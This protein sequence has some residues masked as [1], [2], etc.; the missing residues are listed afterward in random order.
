MRHI[1]L[2][3]VSLIIITL[4]IT[5]SCVCTACAKSRSEFEKTAVIVVGE[6]T[7]RY[8]SGIAI[9]IPGKKTRDVLT[10]CSN[11]LNRNGTVPKTA[12]VIF[13]AAA[14]KSMT[15]QVVDYNTE[16]DLALLRLPEETENLIGAVL[17]E[18]KDADLNDGYNVLGFGY[19]DNGS[20]DLIGNTVQFFKTGIKNISRYNGMDVYNIDVPY[21]TGIIGGALI[22]ND[23]IYGMVDYS[24]ENDYSY[25]VTVDSVISFLRYNDVRYLLYGEKKIRLYIF[26]V[27]IISALIVALSLGI[28]IYLWLRG[29]GTRKKIKDEKTETKNKTKNKFK[30]ETKNKE[31]ETAP[32][33]RVI[34]GSLSGSVFEI[35]DKIMIGR[36]YKRCGIVYPLNENGISSVH[37]V[38]T[39]DGGDIILEDMGSSYGT[40]L[41]SGIAVKPSESVRLSRGDKFYL[42]TKENMFEIV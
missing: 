16:K 2:I 40:F 37:C 18:E 9:G 25:A 22:G 26:L 23:G 21:S 5:L 10:T 20:E 33:V 8:S 1:K 42:A 29:K 14:N 7:S 17:Y 38:I 34:E 35:K 24:K 11:I 41:E 39:A 36:D 30:E 27:L 32:A 6:D 28:I 13:N 15:A 12:Q 3:C 31:K 4:F 19:T